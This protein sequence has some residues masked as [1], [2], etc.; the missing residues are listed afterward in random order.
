MASSTLL[1]V[2]AV[3]VGSLI[4]LARYFLLPPANFPTNIP[5]VPFWYTLIPLFKDNGQE[6]MYRKHLEPKLTKYGAVKLYFGGR[7]NILITKPSYI[8]EVFKYEDTYAKSG[9]QKKIPHSV[10]GEYTG[11]NIISAHGENWRLY[12]RIIKPGLQADVD[13]TL[14]LRNAN[15]LVDILVKNQAASPNASVVTQNTLQQY[16]LQNLSQVLLEAG[17]DVRSSPYLNV[18]SWEKRFH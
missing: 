16:T 11:D 7:W 2:A 3:V 17:F 18:S 4:L 8:A 14:I 15:K 10:L 1:L 5:T 9:N 6:Q 13:G 12:T